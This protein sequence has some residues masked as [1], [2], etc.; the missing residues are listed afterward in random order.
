MAAAYVKTT[1]VDDDG[2]DAVGTVFTATRMNNLENGVAAALFGSNENTLRCLRGLVDMS[3][4]GAT[5]VAPAASAGF[6]VSRTA[7]GVCTVT[8][9]TAYPSRPVVVAVVDTGVGPRLITL[10][11]STSNFV[12]RIYNG[13]TAEDR[14]FNFLAIGPG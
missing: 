4:A 7:L 11:T 14:A 1:W 10:A 2:T 13:T 6:T 9:S 8:F 12:A 5:I 3:T